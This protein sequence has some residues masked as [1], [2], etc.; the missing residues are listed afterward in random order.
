MAVY[1]VTVDAV[2]KDSDL[3]TFI[4]KKHGLGSVQDLVLGETEIASVLKSGIV[5]PADSQGDAQVLVLKG[6]ASMLSEFYDD[7]MESY[8]DFPGLRMNAVMDDSVGM[9]ERQI[10]TWWS[11]HQGAVGRLGSAGSSGLVSLIL[12][13]LFKVFRYTH[14]QRRLKNDV[15]QAGIL[16]PFLM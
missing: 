14:W 12:C 6:T 13:R 8:E 3:I 7:L 10:Q 11:R 2:A 9:I 15:S 16:T 1:E 5:G 4:F